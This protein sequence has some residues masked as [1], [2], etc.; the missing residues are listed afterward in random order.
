MVAQPL[1][2]LR[3]FSKPESGITATPA[4]AAASGG[5]GGTGGT[6]VFRLTF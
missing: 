6:A 5:D 1:A 2:T 4:P 3:R